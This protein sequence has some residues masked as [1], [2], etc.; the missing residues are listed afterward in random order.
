MD[1]KD[2]EGR[3]I[4]EN[5]SQDQ[6]LSVLYSNLAGRLFLRVLAAPIVS[7]AAGEVMN[8]WVS[9]FLIDG[10]VRKHHIPMQ[11][12]ER[13]KYCS[14][15]QFFTRK[16]K[17]GKRI[18][19]HEATRLIAPCDGRCSVYPI[20]LHSIFS[21]KGTSYSVA[22]LLRNKKLAKEYVGGYC[23]IFRLTVEDYHRYCYIDNAIK[24]KN[25]KIQGKFY[26]VHPAVLGKEDI[27]K[28]NTREYCI[29]KTK[30]FG[31]VIQM[32]VGALLVGK[33]RNYHREAMV[34]KGQ[35]KGRFEYG[36]STVVLLF[37]RDQIALD[38]D[39]FLNTKD[40]Y[41]T[42]VHMGEGIGTALF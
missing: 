21:I 13:K 34:Q 25:Y 15:N 42:K 23:V 24:G 8:C 17:V 22:S 38:Q 4:K 1:Y 20:N 3:I 32:E 19:T 36:G 14:Y 12:F 33:I 29:L 5:N 9:T 11:D 30:N 28:E 35:E 16:L 40:G 18:I 7:K 31:K 26:T 6:L 41:E 37:Q 2:R 10:F 27:Y 39:L